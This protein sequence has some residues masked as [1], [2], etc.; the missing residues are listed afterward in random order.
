MNPTLIQSIEAILFATSEPQSFSSL[1]ERLSVSTDEITS[2]VAALGELLRE[3][4]IAVVTY[5]EQVMLATKPQQSELIE[6]IRKEEFN[7]ELSKASSETLAIVAYY[8]GATKAHIEFIRG[9]NGSYTLRALQMR[10]LIEQR[11]LGRSVSYHPTLDLLR[12][13][14]V[15]QIEA[16]PQFS[17]TH[18]KIVALLER[19]AE[20][21]SQTAPTT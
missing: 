15:E 9:V 5:N 10:G 16:L 14:G 6:T 4:G 7:R 11:G 18:Q 21:Q 2:A 13:F 17:Q 12:H 19:G 20:E 8:P 3:H 1:A